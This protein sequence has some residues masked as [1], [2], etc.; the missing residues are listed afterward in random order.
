MERLKSEHV[1][2]VFQTVKKIRGAR[3]QFVGNKVTCNI[4]LVYPLLDCYACHFEED[5]KAG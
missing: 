1:V 3:L 2:D 4:Y 5:G